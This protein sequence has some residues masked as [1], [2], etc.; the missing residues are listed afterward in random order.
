MDPKRWSRPV[1]FEENARGSP[2]GSYCTIVSTK[3]ASR[4]LLTRWPTGSG[5]QYR[6]ARQVCLEVL[7]GKRP[8]SEARR[9]FLE[10]ARE[11]Q[12]VVHEQ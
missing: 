12:V 5:R 9:A 6:K 4:V 3:E 1:T 10:A 11:A 8:P 7:D 2:R